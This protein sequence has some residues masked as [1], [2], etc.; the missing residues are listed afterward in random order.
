MRDA[1]VRISRLQA[2]ARLRPHGT[3][4]RYVGGKCRCADCRAANTRYSRVRYGQVARGE[5]DQLISPD[6]ARRHIL[7]LS[8][9]GVGRR[10]IGD[11]SGVSDTIVQLIRSRR[12]PHIRRSTE[13]RIL[14]VT[15][16]CALDR[17]V[18]ASRAAWRLLDEMLAEGFTKAQLAAWLGLK[19]PALQYKRD[20]PMLAATVVRI[21]RMYRLQQAGKLVRS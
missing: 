12:R 17:A 18:V 21:E 19:T 5:S 6:A 10:A 4:A 11:A 2:T 1:A 14:A 7:R 20:R 16:E 3:R 9:Q 8:R 13:Q 15:V